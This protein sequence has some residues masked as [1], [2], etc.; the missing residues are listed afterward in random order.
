MAQTKTNNTLILTGSVVAAL[1][2]FRQPIG[3]F[4]G[5][6][7]KTSQGVS[8]IA[9]SAGSAAQGVGSGINTLGNEFGETITALVDPFQAVSSKIT[10][11][12]NEPA[13]LQPGNFQG[14]MSAAFNGFNNPLT[15]I[16]A[17]Q[18]LLA[19]MKLPS[20]GRE[21][22][23]A[24]LTREPLQT[25]TSFASGSAQLVGLVSP[26]KLDVI[27]RKITPAL[28]TSSRTTSNRQLTRP[29][30]SRRGSITV[31][32]NKSDKII[33]NRSGSISIIRKNKPNTIIV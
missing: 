14:L 20:Q 30:S 16:R 28:A 26:T 11:A 29:S 8:D 12:I 25:R 2:L 22:T 17:A 13:T 5:G 23:Q 19:G 4:L 27:T 21:P 24:Q 1:F 3:D 10:K 18:S 32:V 7:G 33:K 6:F 31:T 9:T 15:G